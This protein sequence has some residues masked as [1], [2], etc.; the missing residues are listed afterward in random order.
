MD[1]DILKGQFVYLVKDQATLLGHMLE[2]NT[3]GNWEFYIDN[4][5][6]PPDLT[7]RGQGYALRFWK[8][9]IL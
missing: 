5:L 4:A 6:L 7:L 9:C 3:S 8:A 1:T 2:L